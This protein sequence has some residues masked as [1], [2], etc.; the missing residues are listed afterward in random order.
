VQSDEHLLTVLRY[1]E[2]NALAAGLVTRAEHWRWSGL[3]AMLHGSDAIKSVLSLWPVER[4]G[5][6]IGRVNAAL[7]AKELKRVRESIKRGRPFGNDEWVGRTVS[8]LNLEHTI[9]P[10]GRPRIARN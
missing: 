3:W 9:R 4:P 7:S 6:W 10:E 1:V 8:E 5:D 2:R